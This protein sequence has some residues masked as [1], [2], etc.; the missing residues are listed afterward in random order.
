MKIRRSG[1]S[2]EQIWGSEDTVI[3]DIPAKGYMWST[4]NLFM[5][6]WNRD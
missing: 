5:R 3:V 4:T 2:Q 6:K 1:R